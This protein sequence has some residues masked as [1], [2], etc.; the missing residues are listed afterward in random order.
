MKVH[1]ERYLLI[2]VKDFSIT[3]DHFW[4]YC[5]R[6]KQEQRIFHDFLTLYVYDRVLWGIM[7]LM[8]IFRYDDKFHRG[9]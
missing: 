6:L 9:K 2:K 4:T 3:K 8:I 5:R 7:I 1:L